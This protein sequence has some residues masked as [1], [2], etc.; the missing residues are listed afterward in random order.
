MLAAEARL[1]TTGIVRDPT[2]LEHRN[3]GAHPERPQRLQTLYALLDSPA[4]SGRFAALPARDASDEEILRV[5]TSGHLT[6]IAETVNQEITFLDMDTQ[7]CRLSYGAARRAAGGCCAAVEA[8]V[9]REVDNA[10]ALVRPP[11]HHAEPGAA[12]GFCLFNNAAI[13]A[14]H[15]RAAL[16]VERVLV[17]DWDVHHGNG[18]QAVFEEDPSVLYFSTHQWPLYPGTGAL[19]EVG[20]GRGEGATINVPLAAGTGDA[21]LLAVYREVLVPVAREFAPELI[22]VSA[23]FDIHR[24]DPLAGMKATAAG[25]AALTRVLLDLAA[26]LCGGRLLLVLEGGYHLEALRGSV[27][28]TLDELDGRSQTRPPRGLESAAARLQIERV[29]EVHGRWWKA[30]AR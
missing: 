23:G 19:E 2:Y 16:G 18:T 17:A 14:R 3:G 29:R 5:H 22:V 15:A 9:G 21:D 7:A 8:V 12:M 28:A 11:G 26:E 20:T 27:A 24:D 13:A 25:A 4:M 1:A 10:F 6:V 30:L